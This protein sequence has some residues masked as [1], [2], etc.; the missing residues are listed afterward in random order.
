MHYLNGGNDVK[1]LE[2]LKEILFMCDEK[3][4]HDVAINPKEIK[5]LIEHKA[6]KNV[7]S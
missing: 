6:I 3:I 4:D 5:H 7:E 1:L 2:V